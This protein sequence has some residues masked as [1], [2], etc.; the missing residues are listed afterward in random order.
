MLFRSASYRK[1]ITKPIKYREEQLKALQTCLLDNEIEFRN[2]LREDL[3]KS[4]FESVLTELSL[5]YD[6][7]STALD[8]LSSWTSSK[9]QSKAHPKYMWALDSLQLVPEPYGT[10]LVIAPWNYPVQLA[11]S[12]I[13]GA[14]AAGNA[15][16]LKPSEISKACERVLAAL[17]PKYLDEDTFCVV[18]GAKEETQ[19]LLEQKF[20]YIFFTGSTK[21]GKIVMKAAAEHLTP[22]TLELGGKSPVIIDDSCDLEQAAQRI[23]W[24][25]FTNAGQTCV[26][27]DYALILSSLIPRFTEEMKKVITEMFGEDPQQSK[28]YGRIITQDHFERISGYLSQGEVLYGGHADS[29]ERYIQPTILGSIKQGAD[30]MQDEIFGPILPLIPIE[31]LDEAV[32][33]I[34]ERPKPLALYLFTSKS[35]VKKKFEL[36][37]SSGSM[38]INDTLIHLS[39][40]TLPFGGVGDSGMG[41]YH[42]E[43]SFKTFSH[44]KPVM[45]KT[46]KLEKLNEKFRYP[47]YDE[48]KL[49]HLQTILRYPG[50]Q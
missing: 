50:K 40:N 44:M 22:V 11:L 29:E 14:I 18:T 25:K 16:V 9:S 38:L 15:V 30:V 36:E 39:C 17:L 23:A 33:F 37:T 2:A 26:A 10:V 3:H 35:E 21:V 20:D 19:K 31:S 34:V 13:V 42:G 43:Y 28:D 41:A 47:P 48:K 32:S 6:E 46:T 45:H 12:P 24:G 49:S 4:E 1:G 27:P 8:N 5:V 7:I